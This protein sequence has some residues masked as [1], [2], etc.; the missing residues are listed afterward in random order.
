M[1][2]FFIKSAIWIGG[3]LVGVKLV[4]TSTGTAKWLV[5]GLGIYVGAKAFKVI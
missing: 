3:G 2:G 4:K 5:T 1:F